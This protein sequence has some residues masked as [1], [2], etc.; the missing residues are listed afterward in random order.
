[1]VL[2]SV[3]NALSAEVQRSEFVIAVE[4]ATAI[5]RNGQILGK[6]AG[7]ARINEAAPRIVH[8][9]VFPRVRQADPL[10]SI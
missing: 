2:G 3:V 10:L 1:M 4:S 8:P 7:R 9:V 6:R 5:G